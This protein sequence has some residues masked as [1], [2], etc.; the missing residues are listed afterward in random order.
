VG[1]VGVGGGLISVAATAAIAMITMIAIIIARVLRVRGDIEYTL[2]S[3]NRDEGL[4][5]LFK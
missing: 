5:K 2:N 3:C 1:L 4:K